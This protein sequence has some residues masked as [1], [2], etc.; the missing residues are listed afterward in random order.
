LRCSLPLSLRMKPHM[1]ESG[2]SCWASTWPTSKGMPTRSRLR[3]LSRLPAATLCSGGLWLVEA[4]SADDVRGLCEKDPFWP[5]GLRK[6]GSNLRMDAGF[7]RRSEVDLNWTRSENA[8]DL[9]PAGRGTMRTGEAC[10]DLSIAQLPG[11][12]AASNSAAKQSR[13]EC[14]PPLS[15]GKKLCGACTIK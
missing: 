8:A 7:R 12:P 11:P 13:T 6:F 10:Q 5:T 4:N 2:R 9:Y 3:G 1:R 15:A 14:S